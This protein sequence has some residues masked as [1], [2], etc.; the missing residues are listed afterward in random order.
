MKLAQRFL[1]TTAGFSVGFLVFYFHWG[2]FL[3]DHEFPSKSGG[4]AL[5]VRD[6]RGTS[7]NATH[8]NG[9]HTVY[10]EIGVWA[11]SSEGKWDGEFSCNESG[12][13]VHV[14]QTTDYER[15][16]HSNALF[17]IHSAAFSWTKLKRKRPP[18]QIWIYMS[19]ESPL[20]SLNFNHD[21][22]L[23]DVNWTFTYRFDATFPSPYGGYFTDKP[24]V[25]ASDT[26]NWAKGKHGVVCAMVSHCA[27]GWGRMKMIHQLASYISTDIYGS[28]GSRSC[29][30]DHSCNKMLSKYKFYLAFE[31][32]ECNG[33]ITEKFWHNALIYNLVPVVYGGT[34]ADYEKVAPPNSFIHVK[35]FPSLKHLAEYLKL[36]DRNDELYNEYFDW[37]K[38]G[39]VE[40]NLLATYYEPNI[41]M[42]RIM[43]RLLEVD[44]SPGDRSA[45]DVE[46]IYSYLHS[47]R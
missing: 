17:L 4:A 25:L 28:C 43:S 30:R 32:S 18:G 9:G 20:N 27:D 11:T 38:K 1:I 41:T 39:R 34:P 33:Y 42:C 36:L 19:F 24:T 12:T 5:N 46:E 3:Y 26:T 47:C 37:K 16:S 7:E 2:N 8:V 31:N 21:V 13:K 45:K 10:K 23:N 29:P 40:G 35:N 14:I 15:L 22:L 44:K 6:Y